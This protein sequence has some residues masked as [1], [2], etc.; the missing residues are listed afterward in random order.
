MFM[1]KKNL[2]LIIP[3]AILL[4][5]AAYFILTQKNVT[6]NKNETSFII[7]DTAS[8][9]KI[10]ITNSLDTVILTKTEGRW[11]VNNR[12]NI[13]ALMLS[14]CLKVLSEVE[15]QSAFSGE[16]A[17]SISEI[18]LKNGAKVEVSS[19]TKTIATVWYFPD[20]ARKM[21]YAMA[22]GTNKPF[23]VA[24][25]SYNGNFAG[26]F[27]SHHRAWRNEN[28]TTFNLKNINIVHVTDYI[29]KENSFDLNI[30]QNGNAFLNT[31]NNEALPVNQKALQMYLLGFT[32]L[33]ATNY[34]YNSETIDSIKKQNKINAIE[35]KL[36]SGQSFS[37]HIYPKG[38]PASAFTAYVLT[39]SAELTEVKYTQI[40]PLTRGLDFL[41]K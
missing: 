37:F 33:Q 31:A 32:S 1:F 14:L 36:F 15:I 40:D 2:K 25:P 23:V 24:I 21:V 10:T 17:G 11:I 22:D 28:I 3:F 30:T 20:I 35:V 34:L 29:K 4:S 16:M 5:M 13:N 38:N 7:K 18:I 9:N 27:Y 39:D 26:V 8:I 6:F 12:Y 41:K 19:N